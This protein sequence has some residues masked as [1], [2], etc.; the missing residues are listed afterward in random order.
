MQLLPKHKESKI[1]SVAI[2]TI[3][4][5]GDLSIGARSIFT[6]KHGLENCMPLNT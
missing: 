2:E 4:Q 5:K 3:E 6:F 1:S